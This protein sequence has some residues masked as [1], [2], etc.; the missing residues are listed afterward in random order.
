MKALRANVLAA[1]FVFAAFDAVAGAP[2]LTVRHDDSFQ[3]VSALFAVR[4]CA[5]SYGGQVQD[6]AE[7]T[8]PQHV[9]V[10]LFDDEGHEVGQ[11]VGSKGVCGFARYAH[12][13]LQLDRVSAAGS[14]EKPAETGSADPAAR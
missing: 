11:H 1:T 6:I 10:L 12:D 9:I 8:A 7:A 13:Y 2:R 5:Q 4:A 3:G 14:G